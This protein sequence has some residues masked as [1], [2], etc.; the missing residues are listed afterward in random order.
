MST[1]TE[2]VLTLAGT[3]VAAYHLG[4]S[5]TLPRART[6]LR[7]RISRAATRGLSRPATHPARWAAEAASYLYAS[8]GLL[9]ALLRDPVRTIC[10]LRQARAVRPAKL[11]QELKTAATQAAALHVPGKPVQYLRIAFHHPGAR[12]DLSN[13][14]FVHSRN[15]EDVTRVTLGGDSPGF[16]PAITPDLRAHL[17]A[18]RERIETTLRTVRVGPNI[19]SISIP[20]ERA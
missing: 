8:L 2:T 3:A 11:P 7:Y 6:R 14:T 1:S 15:P 16:G 5:G 13:V 10:L 17:R 20:V 4:A 12:P 9:S 19:R 18:S